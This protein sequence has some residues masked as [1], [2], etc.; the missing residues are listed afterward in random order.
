MKLPDCR[1][2]FVEIWCLRGWIPFP[3]ALLS[4]P[5]LEG[6]P[7]SAHISMIPLLTKCW[8]IWLARTLTPLFC[9]NFHLKK[10]IF[11]D[12]V[13][14]PFFKKNLWFCWDKEKHLDK[15]MNEIQFPSTSVKLLPFIKLCTCQLFPFLLCDTIQC[16]AV[17][18][19]GGK[20][21]TCGKHQHAFGA[22]P[23]SWCSLWRSIPKDF[24]YPTPDFPSL[25]NAFS[26][27]LSHLSKFL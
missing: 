7:F 24:Y 2:V 20:F 9:F 1:N 15:Q 12:L 11:K 21:R 27:R 14:D 6:T 3:V 5:F 4:T 25:C 17:L 23:H 22:H 26:S 18:I 8:L 19:L 13:L 10:F 16:K